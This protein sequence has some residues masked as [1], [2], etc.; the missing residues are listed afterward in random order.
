MPGMKGPRAKAEPAQALSVA[1]VVV[2]RIVYSLSGHSLLFLHTSA[3]VNYRCWD[4]VPQEAEGGSSWSKFKRDESRSRGK[5]LGGQAFEEPDSRCDR[6]EHEDQPPGL[7]R[8]LHEAPSF[9]PCSH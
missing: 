5:E 3:T 4:T 8:G 2:G 7:R 9:L 6:L 1:E